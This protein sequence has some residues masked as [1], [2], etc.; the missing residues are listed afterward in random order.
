MSV[1]WFSRKLSDGAI[2]TLHPKRVVL[3][4]R[5]NVLHAQKDGSPV[6]RS[7]SSWRTVSGVA[8]AFR[9]STLLVQFRGRKEW[10]R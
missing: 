1:R 6:L 10:D 2:F 9:R 5:V 3:W 4:H 7:E 8:F